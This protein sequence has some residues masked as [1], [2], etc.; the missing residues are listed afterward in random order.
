LPKIIGKAYMSKNAEE[1]A[2]LVTKC[3]CYSFLA[4]VAIFFIWFYPA[5]SGMVVDDSYLNTVKWFHVI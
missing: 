1:K 2:K 3:I 5:L 4:I